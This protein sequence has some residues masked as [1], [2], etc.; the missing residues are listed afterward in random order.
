MKLQVF[1][2]RDRAVDAFMRP[3][4]A[5]SVS[6]AIRSFTDMLG[7]SESP[8]AKHPE[9]YDLFHLGAFDESSGLFETGVP[10]QV[11]IGKDCVR[12]N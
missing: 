7:E 6:A 12:K 1:S 5:Q 9:D 4:F 10:H 8:A 11:A 2:I 3:F